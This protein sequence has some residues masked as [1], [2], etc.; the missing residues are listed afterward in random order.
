MNEQPSSEY[1]PP[2][3]RS[4]SEYLQQL[5]RALDGADPAMIQDALS[6]TEEH[7]RAECAARP[8]DSEEAVLAAIAGTY[9]APEDV[10]AAYRETDRTVQAA[11][12]PR[13]RPGHA[14]TPRVSTPLRRFFAVYGDFRSWTSLMFMLLSLVTG[15]LYF[16]VVVTGLSLSI[17]LS[18][19]IFGIPVF[20]AFIAL[21]RVL[22]LAEGRLLEALTG[23][24]MPRRPPPVA[25]G[26]WWSRIAA[27]LRSARTWT[28]LVY[29]VLMLPL[30]VIYFTLA[31]SLVA[32]GLGLF[33]GGGAELLRAL[34]A[35]LPSAIQWPGRSGAPTGIESLFVGLACLALSGLL[36]T[37]LMHLARGVGR[38]H[39]R[40]A[41]R[42]L[43]AI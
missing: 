23:E 40:L 41:K 38:F 26:S 24:R 33:V 31:I 37:A 30:G 4:I 18:V 7:L 13:S 34:G 43:V 3:P 17:G 6:D 10:A 11:I 42:L 19:L 28:T 36:L 15:V 16:T 5:R 35:D 39:G 2:V 12:A 1:R 27:M 21:T 14:A 25:V 20:L 32:L 29:Q 8:A 22:A 9:G